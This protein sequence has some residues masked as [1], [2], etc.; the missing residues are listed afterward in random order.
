MDTV[1]LWIILSLSA[2]S[3]LVLVWIAT[4]LHALEGMTDDLL[5]DLD[6]I[7]AQVVQ[8]VDQK[9]SERIQ[10]AIE[11]GIGQDFNPVQHAIASWLQNMQP[12]GPIEVLSRNDKGQWVGE[13]AGN[14][15]LDNKTD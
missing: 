15:P 1:L 3:L 5:E 6:P 12:S 11:G 7:L 9:M 13:N 4:R 8:V 2:T 14:P 10:E